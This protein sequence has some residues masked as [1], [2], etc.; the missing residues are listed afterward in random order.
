[1]YNLSYIFHI[2]YNTAYLGGERW[3]SS[4]VLCCQARG[5]R[6]CSNPGQGR[7]RFLFR[8]HSYSA[9]GTT[10]QWIPEPV[11]SLEFTWSEEERV[12]RMGADCRYFGRKEKTQK[13]SNDTGTETKTRKHQDIEKRWRQ[14]HWTPTS[15]ALG[16]KIEYRYLNECISWMHYPEAGF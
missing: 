4:C 1:M 15:C 16:L 2:F 7:S 6:P 3:S 9:S 11:P 10:S 12:E 14:K 13:K 5:P 8:A